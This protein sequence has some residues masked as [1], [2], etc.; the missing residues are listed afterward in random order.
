MS[1]FDKSTIHIV[2]P[3]VP[4]LELRSAGEA[5]LERLRQ[6]KNEQRQFFFHQEKISVDQQRQWYESFEKRPN[7]LMLMTVYE[8]QVFGCMGIRWRE[9]HW[10]IYNVILGLQDF[11]GRGLMGLAFSALLDYAAALK[12]AH[13][14]LQALKHNPA[15][16]WYQKQGFIIT[17]TQES[18]FSM[19]YQ[20]NQVQ[21]VNP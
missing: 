1:M 3:M 21:K 10:D 6:W 18:Y 20:P 16:N 19:M 5:D 8:H 4:A 17:E 14:T 11:G 7:D 13:I 2:I 15:V 9:D 12:P